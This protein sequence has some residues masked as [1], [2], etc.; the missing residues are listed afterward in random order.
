MAQQLVEKRG[1]EKHDPVRTLRM[2]GYGGSTFLSPPVVLSIDDCLF[3]RPLSLTSAIVPHIDH[4][5]HQTDNTLT[6]TVIFGPAA[7]KWYGILTKHV[8]LSSKNGTIAARV[9][10]DQ[11]LFAP[12]NMGTSFLSSSPHLSLST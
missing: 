8:N 7:T 1:I 11:L 9:A 2:A 3:Y 4:G 12:V 6:K 5:Y 10:C